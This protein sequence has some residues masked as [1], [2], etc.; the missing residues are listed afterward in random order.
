MNKFIVTFGQQHAHRVNNLTFDKDSVAVV[1]A[2]NETEARKFCFEVFK[3]EYH[4]CTL[5]KY[6]DNN[7]RLQWFPRGKMEAN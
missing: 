4:N 1:K 3:N 6:F 2:E 5:E 7:N